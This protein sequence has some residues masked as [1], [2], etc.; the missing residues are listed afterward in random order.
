MKDVSQL[1][2]KKLTNASS[3]EVRKQVHSVVYSVRHRV[4]VLFSD[5]LY[6]LHTNTSFKIVN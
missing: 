4:D 1:I 6:L 2:G 3:L 5:D